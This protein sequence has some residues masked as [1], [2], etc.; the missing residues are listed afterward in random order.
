MP[1]KPKVSKSE[2]QKKASSPQE[3]PKPFV[4]TGPPFPEDER[5]RL[6]GAL[7]KLPR[8][9]PEPQRIREGRRLLDRM[10]GGQTGD[11]AAPPVRPKRK[12][13]S[14][15]G[16]SLLLSAVDTKRAQKCLS[17]LLKEEPHKWRRPTTAA[18]YITT[19]CLKLREESWQT[20]RD[21]VVLPLLER[22]GLIAPKK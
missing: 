7:S 3:P 14:D 9:P 20:V 12:T 16:Q 6:K 17:G 13:R 4:Y 21:Q 22:R 2:A 11:R 10:M 5:Q 8:L 19:E 18:K 15:K 1:K